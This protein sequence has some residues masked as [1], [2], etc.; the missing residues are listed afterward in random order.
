ML[1]RMTTAVVAAALMLVSPL[2][3]A[4][5]HAEGKRAKVERLVLRAA[6]TVAY[7][8]EDSAFGALRNTADR[9]K[10]M[11]IIPNSIRAG[12]ILGGS[13]GNAVMVARGED[14]QWTQ[15]VFFSV[16]SASF[17][18]QIGAESSE[19]VL[20]VMT[21]RGMEHL[22]S[23]SVKLGGDVS[24]AAGPVGAGA[25]AQTTDILAFSRSRGL[26]GGLSLE[27]ALLKT[28]HDYNAAYYGADVRPT[29]VIYRNNAYNP[30]SATLQ[31]AVATLAGTAAPRLAPLQPTTPGQVSSYPGQTR[32]TPQYEDDAVWGERVQQPQSQPAPQPQTP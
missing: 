28:R 22:L 17:G 21:Q 16:G 20:L 14:G 7:F 1:M 6:E 10:A 12:F 23:T 8:N 26:Y 19:T 15:P 31:Q 18:F 9:A 27:G 13:G 3:T 11:V 30:R 29:D 4:P 24:I 32:Q 2:L 5:A 25:K